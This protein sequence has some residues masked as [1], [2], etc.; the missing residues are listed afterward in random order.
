MSNEPK[1]FCDT[2]NK[3]TEKCVCECIDP[4]EPDFKWEYAHERVSCPYTQFKEI[5]PLYENMR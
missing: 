2:C 1:R 5:Q 4:N 3:L